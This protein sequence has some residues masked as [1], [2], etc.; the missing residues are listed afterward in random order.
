MNSKNKGEFKALLLCIKHNSEVNL[1]IVPTQYFVNMTL[2]L[3]RL[4]NK[5]VPFFV[6]AVM[7]IVF[8]SYFDC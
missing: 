8:V 2:L 7:E 6:F 4:I 3:G 5:T 1:L